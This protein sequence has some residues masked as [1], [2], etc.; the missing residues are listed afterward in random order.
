MT[1]PSESERTVGGGARDAGSDA[2]E[3]V[4]AEPLLEGL[5]GEVE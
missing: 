5:S 3:P 1:K 2:E 4:I